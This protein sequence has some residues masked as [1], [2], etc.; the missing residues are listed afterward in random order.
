MPVI[1]YYQTKGVDYLKALIS[2]D[3]LSDVAN[4]LIN[5]VSDAAGW[6][7]NHSTPKREGLS[8]YIEEVQKMDISPLEKAAYISNAKRIMKEYR[9]QHD[10]IAQ[11][12][13]RLTPDAQPQLVS[14]DWIAQLMDK[15]RLVSESDFQAIWGA[16]LAEECN[17]PGSIPK[18][19]LHVLSQ[20]DRQHAESF[21]LVCSLS[22][23]AITDL[24][25]EYS[26]VIP[27]YEYEDF[28]KKVGLNY[29]I[30]VDLSS[31]GLI[32]M[33]VVALASSLFVVEQ[34]QSPNVRYFDHTYVLPE[35]VTRLPVGGVIF[36]RVGL[37]LCKAIGQQE[38][39]GFFESCCVPFWKSREQK[40]KDS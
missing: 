30:L 7:V 29:D 13:Q 16:I 20:M 34:I 5:K 8:I 32:K 2:F 36:S 23:K 14:D 28:F 10:V 26:P 6:S 27:F 19:L 35:G 12:I 21:A 9:N 24:G 39:D 25:V 38:I 18:A 15:T 33:D 3:G 31:I 4:N 1:K 17:R 40:E 11:A 22:V 37:A